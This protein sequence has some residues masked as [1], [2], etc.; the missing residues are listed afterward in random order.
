M[1]Y[2]VILAALFSFVLACSAHAGDPPSFGSVRIRIDSSQTLPQT[3]PISE[4]PEPKPSLRAICKVFGQDCS[5]PMAMNLKP[6]KLESKR[7]EHR[8]T[9]ESPAGYVL[10]KTNLIE[11][12]HSRGTM[13]NGTYR[14]DGSSDRL[15][16][17]AVVPKRARR[18]AID[19][20]VNLMY[21]KAQDRTA[22]GCMVPGSDAFL[23]HWCCKPRPINRPWC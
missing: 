14:S 10:C 17:F 21:V 6:L 7:G 1:Q 18:T 13:L 20:T 23:C 15:D 9:I 19:Y 22:Y 12:R 3:P 11:R 2:L 4:V 16:I 5:A 8:G